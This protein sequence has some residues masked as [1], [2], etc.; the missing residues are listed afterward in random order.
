MAILTFAAPV[1]G[2]RG[3]VGGNI[4]SANRSGPYLKAW[5]RGS[6]P[7]TQNQTNHRAQLVRFAQAWS[8]L[9]NAE[10][11]GWDT[12]AALPAQDKTNSLGETF[13]ASGFNWYIEINLNLEAAGESPRD[14]AP[15]IA[16]P[17]APDVNRLDFTA[18]PGGEQLNMRL[19]LSD[20]QLGLK[21]AI[22]CVI[23]NSDG[24]TAQAEIRNFMLTRLPVGGS[25]NFVFTTQAIARFGTLQEGQKAFCLIR[26]QT[27]EGRRGPPGTAQNV[28]T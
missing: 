18:N 9:S 23:T 10:R 28:A 1:A 12:Y 3:K 2:L 27:T 26:A 7:R 16:T 15:T 25:A 6:N 17:A 19:Q 24:R 8:A 20:P 14:N 13:S 21:H 5:G 4:F 11:D 22:F